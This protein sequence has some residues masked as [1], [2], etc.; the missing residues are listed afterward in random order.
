MI[1]IREYDKEKDIADLKLM[2]KSRDLKESF[3]QTLPKFCAI[4]YHEGRPT[5]FL[6]IR[7]VEGGMGLIESAVTNRE[8]EPINRDLVMDKLGLFI[9]KRAKELNFIGLLFV[10]SDRNTILRGAKHGGAILEQVVVS[11]YF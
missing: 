1:E 4:G 3:V 7:E 8:I 9:Q 11:K 5:A 10:T 6:C 2:L